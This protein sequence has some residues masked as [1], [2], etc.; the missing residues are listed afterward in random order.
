MNPTV[1]HQRPATLTS[2]YYLWS[3]DWA[4]DAVS[5][6]TNV[7]RVL[8]DFPRSVKTSIHLKD[9]QVIDTL[10]VRRATFRHMLE[11]VSSE[12]VFAAREINRESSGFSSG[13]VLSGYNQ[14][15]WVFLVAHCKYHL[16]LWFSLLFINVNW[17][18]SSPTRRR[19]H[20]AHGCEAHDIFGCKL[21]ALP[22][23]LA[24][25][26]SLVSSRL[27]HELFFF[28]LQQREH[29]ESKHTSD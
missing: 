8:C 28:Y 24:S 18:D 7:A 11:K 12:R 6:F 10:W 13:F 14:V 2:A 9:E 20:A 17:R 19:K 5:C 27:G 25:L 26:V 15:E 1:Q 16:Q 22:V 3:T 23:T 21:V 4:V 29:A